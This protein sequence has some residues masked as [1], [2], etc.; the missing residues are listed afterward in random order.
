MRAYLY[1]YIY[2]CKPMD[3]CIIKKKSCV[4]TYVFNFILLECRMRAGPMK[5]SYQIE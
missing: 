2:V 3:V 5:V 4:E 1:V